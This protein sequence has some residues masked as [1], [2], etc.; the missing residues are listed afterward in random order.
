VDNSS[1]TM[2][3]T[4]TILKPGDDL[5]VGAVD[6][7]SIFG[8]NSGTSPV[9]WVAYYVANSGNSYAMPA[10]PT[11]NPD[12]GV[13][14][15][16]GWYYNTDPD[17]RIGDEYHK[18]ETPP[19][20]YPP[21][22]N[23]ILWNSAQ[24]QEMVAIDPGL[25]SVNLRII[26]T[27]HL[28]DEGIYLQTLTNNGSYQF[29]GVKITDPSE[30]LYTVTVYFFA[31]DQAGNSHTETRVYNV[32]PEGDRPMVS[33]ITNPKW[34]AAEA[35]KMMNGR[36]RISGTAKDNVRVKNVWFRVYKDDTKTY[37][38]NL[39]IPV[40]D[41]SWNATEDMQEGRSLTT[42]DNK[43][44]GGNW[45]MANIGGG[46]SD[47]SW[48]AYI[49]TEGELDPILT[50]SAKITIEVM[51]EDTNRTGG[52]WDTGTGMFSTKVP[53][54]APTNPNIPHALAH[55]ESSA[56][57]VSG[58]P[59]FE[60]ELVLAAPSATTETGG[61]IN[62][63]TWGSKLTTYLKGRSSYA[64]H[65]KHTFGVGKIMWGNINLL[66]D[67]AV[68]NSAS[69][70]Y[71]KGTGAN[72]YA[73]DIYELNNKRA[74]SHNGVAVKAVP[75]E[76]K[77]AA[78]LAA[79]PGKDRTFLIWEPFAAYPASPYLTGNKRSAVFTLPKG[80][81]LPVSD[82]S[83]RLMEMN[84]EYFEWMV[85]VDIYADVIP[86][87]GSSTDT[88]AGK[89]DNYRIEF[90]A[91]E[92]SKTIPLV[93]TTNVE[94]P[95]D[96]KPPEG[97]YTHNNYVAG[98]AA[99]F[100]GSAGDGNT[101]KVRGLSRIVLWFTRGA[102]NTPFT[103]DKTG[104]F[105]SVSGSGTDALT[106]LPNSS[107]PD[108]QS[109]K[110][111]VSEINK[112]CIVIEDSDPLGQKLMYGHR[113]PMG[114]ANDTSD[115]GTGWYVTLD[116][117]KLE[118]G[119]ITAHYIVYDKAGNAYYNSKT[120]I[121]MN[122]VPRITKIT[123]ATDIRGDNNLTTGTNPPFAGNGTYGPGRDSGTNLAAS[124]FTTI[125]GKFT[126]GTNIDRGISDPISI[127]TDT[128]RR[129]S[130]V[131][132]EPFNVRNNLLAVKVEVPQYQ[133]DGSKTRTFRVE[134]VSGAKLL[135]GYTPT[136]GAG[137][138]KDIKAGRIYMIND[139]GS[140]ADANFPWGSWGVKD[141][142][143]GYQKGV[144]FMAVE[145][146]DKVNM[147]TG[148][149]YA[150]PSVWELN[151]SYYPANPPAGQE[152]ERPNVFTDL[153]LDDVKYSA[154]PS[155]VTGMSAEFVYG[156]S[157]FDSQSRQFDAN[158]AAVDH[159]RDFT[160]T[161][162]ANSDGRPAPYPALTANQYPWAA[163]S[164]FIVRVFGGT[165]DELFGD[166][167]LLSIRVN[168]NDR[169]RPYAQIYDLNPKTEGQEGQAQTQAQALSIPY[170]GGN[171]TK[172]GLYNE[173]DTQNIK[174]SGHIEPYNKT[175]L[176]SAEMGGAAN[177]SRA[178]F[179]KPFIREEDKA[180]WLFATDT[181]S[182][183]V[184]LRGYVEDDQRIAGVRLTFTSSVNTRNIDILARGGG[185]ALQVP[186]TTDTT[187]RVAWTETVDL[188]RH[189]VEWAY[190]W[191]TESIPGDTVVGDVTVTAIAYNANAA[192]AQ[193]TDN[194]SQNWTRADD[195]ANPD[196]YDYFNV[197]DDYLASWPR[198][199]RI[200]VNLRP[201]ITGFLR[202]KTLFAH[203]TRS[204]QGRYMFHQGETV[205]VQGFNLGSSGTGTT[206]NNA[207]I[208][209]GSSGSTPADVTTETINYG[210]PAQNNARYR[211][212]TVPAAAT[213]GNGMVTLSVTRDTAYN[214][215][216]TGSGRAV[217]T[218][219]ATTTNPA[220]ARPN[221]ILPWNTEYS[222]G[223]DGSTL[224]DDFTQVH[225]WQSGD[226]NN[227][228]NGGRFAISANMV[229][230]DPAMT[231]N[232]LNGLL[233]VSF[234]Q[235]G[236]NQGGIDTN[237]INSNTI[238][239]Q[240]Q[241]CD[242]I[243]TSDIFIRKGVVWTAY[244]IIGEQGGADAWREI[245]GIY[246]SGPNG[247]NAQLTSGIGGT[248]SQYYGESTAYDSLTAAQ[249]GGV[250]LPTGDIRKLDQFKNPHIVTSQY[251]ANNDHIHVSYYDTKDGSIKYR[252]NRQNSAGTI[253]ANTA[254]K[255]WTNLDG[256]VDG[257]DQSQL[258]ASGAFPAVA[259]NGRI[260]NYTTSLEATRTARG[261]I[262]AG[263][264][265][266]IA[267]TSNGYP[268]IAY[269]DKTNQ[270]LKMAIS[271]NVAPV[272]ASYWTIRDNV[273]PATNL[274]HTGTGQYVSMKID[275][276]VTPNVVHIAALN[277]LN[278]NL[279]YIKGTLTYNT[280]NPPVPTLTVSENDIVVV[281][282][283][284][285]V[286]SWCNLSLDGQ[287]RP[288]IA[289]KDES[290]RGSRDGVKVAYFNDTSFY[291]GSSNDTVVVNRGK[292]VDRW[293]KSIT[294]WEALNVPTQYRVLD[295]SASVNT[296]LG[297]E[298]FPTRNVNATS[299]T[300]YFWA[301]A[302]AVGYLSTDYYRVAYYVK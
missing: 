155:T 228:A 174:K 223:R 196:L 160:P 153:R 302:A 235:A 22:S 284:G 90:S 182:G 113:L 55:K 183:D 114:F 93:S 206:V 185:F 186:A 1:P 122:G 229:P 236:S 144:A 75:K 106:G 252:Y 28:Q 80:V 271:S 92:T 47:I 31:I 99:T 135:T 242:P 190:L 26:N 192:L 251:D 280:A 138:L 214:A 300:G 6:I 126:S 109:F 95:I 218:A 30:E 210:I 169:T 64:I 283:V 233:Y 257:D 268:V 116:S 288:W 275:T 151:S 35:E 159:I 237:P 277:S 274:N 148:I 171:R 253:D 301:G 61:Q 76:L 232:P 282:S 79:D 227:T 121:V 130:V 16:N 146:G 293:G 201:Y 125:E 168:N 24:T 278:R 195:T 292:D 4:N 290:Y 87:N 147:P 54:P 81:G 44:L 291:K 32:Y 217:T 23:P 298:C 15:P 20:T 136:G 56:I 3:I 231:I 117:T 63:S 104:S 27:R 289:Y 18:V 197:N 34:G 131:Y 208:T 45:Y 7:Q 181:V 296:R 164:L 127:N 133:G 193:K 91:T 119:K 184:I 94:I 209:L 220:T 224:W 78:V 57:V 163:H 101:E 156:A 272:A 221:Y 266:A 270:K 219:A 71:N 49:N 66:D 36:I 249:G 9:Q 65:V 212:F 238:T 13:I 108:W 97:T 11:M 165:E 73:N 239:R 58:A 154:T 162:P 294:G 69:Y 158:G 255:V 199:N 267:L 279:V 179:A 204:R 178:T 244:S 203:D 245:G 107:V 259:A 70:Q 145:D 21:V 234:S 225:I 128:V 281:D 273:I 77:T 52:A 258:I 140:G 103:W 222:P 68:T 51:A 149:S 53:S 188:N 102:A 72:T 226:T 10:V 67:D 96:N 250:G 105:V 37:A 286:G 25:G 205:V 299:N 143:D 260:K 230:K 85:V 189:R 247:G 176:T 248:V 132:D 115:L 84:G 86:Y 46:G 175:I 62:F 137:S 100:G 173:G 8:K 89:A 150:T 83:V 41:A 207:A 111:A 157:A 60:D 142:T 17:P 265:N 180:T 167:A 202:N 40:W 216:N 50:N 118:S 264:H 240:A 123:L 48:W 129:Y 172:G 177:S 110:G 19:V 200:T 139:P 88:Y 152:L 38:A 98:Q 12:T 74:G 254:P 241:F 59:R 246:M 124:P 39:Q 43:S 141:V 134:Y 256:G 287:G 33:D 166:F 215:V 213:T 42:S 269:Y 276:T 262:D 170:M 194:P 112:S 211:I 295:A 198:Y 161:I 82:T 120:L 191:N 297:M 187:N 261:N 243:I 5:V 263:E 29:N 285:I 14:N 2:N